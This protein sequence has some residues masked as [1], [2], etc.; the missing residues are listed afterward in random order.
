MSTGPARYLLATGAQEVERLRLLEEAYGPQSQALLRRASL[1]EGL[2][3]VE[4]GCG[5]G[6]VTCWLAA[7]V[8]AAIT[9]APGS[10]RWHDGPAPGAVG[11]RQWGV[12]G[13]GVG[14]GCLSGTC[15]SVGGVRHLSCEELA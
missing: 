7:Q 13:G 9:I 8:G 5:S 3:V 4:V 6:N 12:G 10:R 11:P 14:I 2:R 1:R 15:R